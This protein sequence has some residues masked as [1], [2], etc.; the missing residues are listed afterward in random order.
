MSQP[1]FKQS[2]WETQQYDDLSKDDVIIWNNWN[3]RL[4]WGLTMPIMC[5]FQPSWQLDESNTN[6][7]TTPKHLT[8]VL[9]TLGLDYP[10]D[11][12][13]TH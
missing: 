7:I 3:R 4:K 13:E 6:V 5:M 10:Q 2:K 11:I 9:H 8:E 1:W 12:E